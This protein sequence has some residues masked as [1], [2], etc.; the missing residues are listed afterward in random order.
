MNEAAAAIAE[1]P[2]EDAARGAVLGALVGDAAGAVLEFFAA[3]ITGAD[4]DHAL[5]MPG[6]GTWQGL[7]H[8]NASCVDA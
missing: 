7:S 1:T 6:G 8:P 4:V 2:R 3:A 5:S